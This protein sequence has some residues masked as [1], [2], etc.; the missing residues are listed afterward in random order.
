MERR[1]KDKDITNRKRAEGA[2]LSTKE[3]WEQTFDAVSNLLAII[4]TEYQFVHVNKAM[5]ARLGRTPEECIGLTCYSAVH[6]TTSPPVFCPHKRLIED[7]HRHTAEVNEQHLGGHFFI[8][9]SPLRDPGDKLF[10]SVHVLHDITQQKQAEQ[11]LR[12]LASKL[13]LVGEQERREIAVGLHDHI[14]QTLAASNIKLGD[15][16]SKPA[17]RYKKPLNEIREL[18]DLA[19]QNTRSLTFDLS[20]PVLYELGLEAAIEWLAEKTQKEHGF[21]ID[22]E[23]PSSPVSMDHEIRILLFQIV[24]ELLFNVVKHAKARRV[25]I[26]VLG[27]SDEIRIRVKDDGVGFDTS[28]VQLQSAEGGGFG[29][30][31]IR[32][33]LSYFRGIL[34]IVPKLRLGTDVTITAPLTLKKSE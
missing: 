28:K 27:D 20:P 14:G 23:R 29:F 19:I 16:L 34:E 4:N 8:S 10:G 26:S 17:L 9:V 25:R 22:V 2:M 30:F 11:K 31:S 7:G 13:L 32:E 21:A 15:L 6:G 5:A 24:R 12:S 1:N 3:A 33:R 18:I